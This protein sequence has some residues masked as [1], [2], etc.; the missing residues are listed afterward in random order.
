MIS[1]IDIVKY[2]G[3]GCLTY[4]FVY[5][6]PLLVNVFNIAIIHGMY[7]IMYAI[8]YL[9]I[10]LSKLISVIKTNEIISGFLEANDYDK[11]SKIELIKDGYVNS[12]VY[13]HK[14]K[15]IIDHPMFNEIQYDFLL[16]SY[17]NDDAIVYKKIL[18]ECKIEEDLVLDVSTVKFILTEIIVG[19]NAYKIDLSNDKHNYY[20]VDNVIDKHVVSY[21]LNEYS[22]N[23]KQIILDDVVDYTLKII[24]NDANIYL[25]PPD[26]SIKILKDSYEII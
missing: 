5:K 24:D 16:F 10:K 22:F 4:A 9:Q 17:K 26:K 25:L 23:E 12:N 2:A 6:R 3:V 21:L 15:N 13:L 8:S 19:D 7:N 1:S 20:I 14:E 11:H 18:K